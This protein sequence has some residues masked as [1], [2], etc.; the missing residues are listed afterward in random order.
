[1]LEDRHV[2]DAD[3]QG[4]LKKMIARVAEM[5]NRKPASAVADAAPVSEN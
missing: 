2:G 1:V 3:I 5:G 4:K